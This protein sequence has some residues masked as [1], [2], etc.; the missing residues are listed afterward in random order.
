MKTTYDQLTRDETDDSYTIIWKA[1]IPYK[2]KIFIWLLEQGVVLTKE[3]MIRRKWVGDPSC[4][5]CESTETV[6]HLFFQCPTAKVVWGIVAQLIGAN[7]IPVNIGQFWRW[8]ELCLP[9]CKY[10]HT[11]GLAAICWAIWKA[12]NKACFDKKLIKHPAEIICHACA[13]MNFWRGLHKVDLQ[14]QIAEGLKILL[15]SA[16][17]ILLAQPN[18]PP[19]PLRLTTVAEEE[20]QEEGDEPT[21]TT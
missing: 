7:N 13:F 3:N 11:F 4:R 21:P 19:S 14:A 20:D 6:D 12:W 5:F 8:I 16:C 9:N 2:I 1:K 17:R 10:M 18:A 15:S